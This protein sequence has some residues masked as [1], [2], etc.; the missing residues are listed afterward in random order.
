MLL[1]LIRLIFP[2][3]SCLARGRCIRFG[4]LGCLVRFIARCV[5]CHGFVAIDTTE[6]FLGILEGLTRFRGCRR[7]Q[8]TV[9][10]VTNVGEAFDAARK[11]TSFASRNLVA[12]ATFVAATLLLALKLQP[13]GSSSPRRSPVAP[14]RPSALQGTQKNFQHRSPRDI[15]QLLQ[16][17]SPRHKYYRDP[18]S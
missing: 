9:P 5:G 18:Q 4:L 2:C 6:D 13:L 3:C 8:A 15:S 10:S 12:Q 11:C 7:C 17:T 1:A 16:L 14:P